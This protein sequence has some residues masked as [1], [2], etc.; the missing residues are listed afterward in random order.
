[1]N[2]GGKHR[3]G[4]MVGVKERLQGCFMKLHMRRF[5]KLLS[6]LRWYRATLKT[7][8]ICMCTDSAAKTNIYTLNK[9]A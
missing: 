9:N 8:K 4:T 6:C 2:K 3:A 1:L 5:I 7:R